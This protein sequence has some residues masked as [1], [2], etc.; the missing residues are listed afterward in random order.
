MIIRPNHLGTTRFGFVTGKR[1]GNAVTRNRSR[2]LMREAVRRVSDCIPGGFDVVVIAGR[3]SVGAGYQEI[4]RS[5]EELA[6]RAGL[7]R[8]T[9]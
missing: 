7:L 6:G 3:R 1:L 5:V 8:E 9:H 4:C 2:R